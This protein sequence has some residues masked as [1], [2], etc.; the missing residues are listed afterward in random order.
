[1][2]QKITI[3][4]FLLSSFFACVS[5]QNCENCLI[6]AKKDMLFFK[7]INEKILAQAQQE[8]IALSWQ[9]IQGLLS[10]K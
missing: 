4:V 7:Q 3:F 5:C 2:K 9:D 8:L 6:D 1:M 10:E